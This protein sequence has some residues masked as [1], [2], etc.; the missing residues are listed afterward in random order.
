[1]T[2]DA[3]QV[4]TQ[5]ATTNEGA[6]SQP[7]ASE[8]NQPQASVVENPSEQ[9][10]PS[11]EAQPKAES[12]K[13]SEI[14]YKLTPP[15]GVTLDPEAESE[16]ISVAKELGLKNEGAQ[17]LLDQRLGLVSKIKQELSDSV[18]AQKN[19]WKEQLLAD[20]EIGGDNL[21][22]NLA[23]VAKA[24]DQFASKELVSFLDQT[25]LGGHPEL[26]KLL[27]K[28][29]KSISED[30]VIPQKSSVAVEK[31]DAASILYPNH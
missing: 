13:P 3:N 7:P 10:K 31:K 19:A 30:A 14:E 20:K 28:V 22:K 5:A 23:F 6:A 24:R 8:A 15:E 29:G 18:E 16:I 9:A 12:E 21:Q 26:V 27:Y 4:S 25:G 17:K 1:M 2:T 11:E